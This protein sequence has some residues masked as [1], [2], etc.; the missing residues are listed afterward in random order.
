[1][2]LDKAKGV[3][4]N[5]KCSLGASTNVI[6]TAFKSKCTL[7]QVNKISVSVMQMLD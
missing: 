5:T 2:V 6:C 1:M 4:R 7:L 3:T